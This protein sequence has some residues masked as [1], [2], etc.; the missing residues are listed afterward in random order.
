MGLSV[1][2]QA[3]PCS[4][5]VSFTICHHVRIDDLSE[6]GWVCDEHDAARTFFLTTWSLFC[7]AG[8]T[9]AWESER[10]SQGGGGT[11]LMLA[12]GRWADLSEFKVREQ[13]SEQRRLHRKI[14]LGAWGAGGGK[15][16][17]SR[18]ALVSKGSLLPP[19]ESWGWN[20]GCPVWR[21]APLPTEPP[22]WPPSGL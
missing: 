19:C 3:D 11:G 14:L 16:M 21:Q 9:G 10:T 8:M 22:R 6:Q 13:I 1:L 20:F 7:G 17:K 5:L 18:G 2:S 4:K 15:E 12:L